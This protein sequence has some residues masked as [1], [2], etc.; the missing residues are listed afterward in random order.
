[1]LPERANEVVT[2]KDVLLWFGF[3]ARDGLFPS[4]PDIRLPAAPRDASEMLELVEEALDDIALLVEFRIVG[5]L[6]G[7][8]ALGRDHGL[9]SG[10]GD[11]LAEVV[12]VIALVSD[13]DFGGDPIDQ[14][15]R[16]GDVVSLTGRGDQSHWVAQR[17]ASGVDLGA[18]AAAGAPKAL[19]IRPHFCRRAPAAC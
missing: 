9:A 16:K 14:G 12:G 17:V 3:S 1:M 7:A 6:K 5:A 2:E 19:S 15:M 4:E 10:L 11:L 13:G 18:Q 8:V